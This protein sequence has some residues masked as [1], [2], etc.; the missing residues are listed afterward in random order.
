MNLQEITR[1]YDVAIGDLD[2]RELKNAFDSLRSLIEISGEAAFSDRLLDIEE[3]YKYML[4]YSGEGTVDPKRAE[5]YD[6]L[7][8]RSYELADDIIA[9]ALYKESPMPIYENRR[10]IDASRKMDF[11]TIDERLMLEHE[12]GDR[13]ECDMLTLHLFNSI[14]ATGFLSPDDTSSIRNIL[15]EEELPPSVS[16]QIISALWLGLQNSFDKNKLDLL[17]DAAFLEE[18]EVQVRAVTCILLTLYVYKERT[19]LYPFIKD[20][21]SSLAESTNFAEVATL[22]ILKFISTRDTE[23]I[24][25]KIQEEI[26][27]EIEKLN[28]KLND[29]INLSDL[30][31][32]I[33]G[34]EVNP[35]WNYEEIHDKVEK[36][37]SEFSKMQ[38]EG[39]DVMHSTF[40]GLK[41]FPFFNQV[42][43]WF[44]PFSPE[45]SIFEK[46][47][48]ISGVKYILESMMRTT[49][50]C[51]SDAYSF[52]FTITMLPKAMKNS[53]FGNVSDDMIDKM[54]E[55]DNG[56]TKNKDSEKN[57]TNKYVLDLYRFYKLYK[58]HTNFKDI[59]ELP[60]DFHNLELLRPYLSNE[61]TLTTISDTYL[62][63][64]Y[65]N[66]ALPLLIELSNKE[67]DNDIIYQKLGYCMQMTGD[68]EGALTAYQKAEILNPDNEWTTKHIAAC[69]RLTHKYEKA[70]EYYKKHESM[71]P[72][73][74][75][76]IT[77]IGHC[78]LELKNY[79]Q[80]LN[81]F[82]KVD[83]MDKKAKKAWRPI[84]WC[85]FLTGKFE[86]AEKYYNK[87]LDIKPTA[88]DY[89]NA[90]HT[91]LAQNDTKNAVK[92]YTDSIK[93]YDNDINK[94]KEAFE[95][96]LPDLNS[97]G[98]KPENISITID[99]LRYKIEN[100]L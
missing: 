28:P 44:L 37:I 3:T 22:I 17:F 66:D 16:C 54:K 74:I 98:V 57:I 95:Q 9:K 2:K 32:D 59:F 72:D 64:G 29:K 25:K 26:F 56:L 75:S 18:K 94:F 81:Y 31:F 13:K 39:A 52:F 86:Q 88:Q 5:I 78:Y 68:S 35:E 77:S 36:T 45:H 87:I 70:L 8:V 82:F 14:W 38:K 46:Q 19:D 100:K 43:N 55:L 73:N 40:T 6:N 63:K 33:N 91:C 50:F 27:P 71:Q 85:S 92:Y 21:L 65:Y 1:K 89:M 69:Y 7:V 10:T 67:T 84:A 11:E 48:N 41:D 76:T 83:Y 4:K 61:K 80:A 23:K 42:A 60:L 51:N 12:A 30:P 24:T 99:Y 62:N 34:K 90:G 97:V 15:F 79:D 93:L 49:L 58:S 96:D 20:R 53:I 47:L